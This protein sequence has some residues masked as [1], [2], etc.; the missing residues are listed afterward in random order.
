MKK[1]LT[2][3]EKLNKEECFDEVSEPYETPT[4]KRY[5]ATLEKME[6]CE[7]FSVKYVNKI[8]KILN[9]PRS[10]RNHKNLTLLILED[11]LEIEKIFKEKYEK[12]ARKYE[13]R[14]DAL[15]EEF[16]GWIFEKEKILSEEEKDLMNYDFESLADE[17]LLESAKQQYKNILYGRK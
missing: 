16:Y 7:R 17:D 8:Y 3:L 9:S 2:T 11:N 12:E 5:I 4:G 14:R 10:W 15:P 1:L 6:V 13:A